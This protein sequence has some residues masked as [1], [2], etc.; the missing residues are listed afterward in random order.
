MIALWDRLAE[1]AFMNVSQFKLSLPTTREI[2]LLITGIG[3]GLEHFLFNL[4]Q[5]M[6]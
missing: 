6:V 3:L 1:N 2:G 4:R 5:K